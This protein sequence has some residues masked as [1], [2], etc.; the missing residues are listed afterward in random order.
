MGMG[1]Y[2][3]YVYIKKKLLLTVGIIG[4]HSSLYM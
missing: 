3:V 1:L 2:T 4:S